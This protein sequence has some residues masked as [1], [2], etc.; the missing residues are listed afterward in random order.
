MYFQIYQLKLLKIIIKDICKQILKSL[1][2]LKKY[3]EIG[4][5]IKKKVL[6]KINN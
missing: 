2:L 1:V 3:K 5:N 6:I 4:K